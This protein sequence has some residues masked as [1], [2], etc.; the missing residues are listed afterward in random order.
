MGRVD[1]GAERDG[2]TRSDGVVAGPG[3]ASIRGA[4]A[5]DLD[6]RG[7][8]EGVRRGG[9]YGAIPAV[10]SAVGSGGIQGDMPE[11]PGN[12]EHEGRERSE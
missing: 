2:A 9:F 1:T 3:V 8:G 4:A 6:W 7:I 11:E 12:A 5:D 10:Y